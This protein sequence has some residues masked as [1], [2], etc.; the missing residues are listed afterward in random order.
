MRSKFELVPL[1]IPS[2][3]SIVKNAFYNIE[4]SNE[5]MPD[6]YFS[7]DMLFIKREVMPPREDQFI[8][9]L[10]W[11]PENSLEGN[12]ILVVAVK[13]FEHV[14]KS[15]ESRDRYEI[16]HKLNQ[17]LQLLSEAIHIEEARQALERD[18]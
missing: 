1:Q 2:G 13:N 12:Y 17:W 4:P 6:H 9:S 11:L 18:R 7:E 16:Q 15:F 10:D 5:L 3:W 14:L 8:I